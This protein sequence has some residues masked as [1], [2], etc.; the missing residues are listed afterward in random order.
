MVTS[1]FPFSVVVFLCSKMLSISFEKGFAAN[2]IKHCIRPQ[3]MVEKSAAVI[4]R[5]IHPEVMKE[6]QVA[7]MGHVLLA[8]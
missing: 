5:Q 7:N 4:L 2:A 3:D 8:C 1:T 6:A